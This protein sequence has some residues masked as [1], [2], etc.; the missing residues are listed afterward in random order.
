MLRM[1]LGK[2]GLVLMDT[3]QDSR[4]GPNEKSNFSWKKENLQQNLNHVQ[5]E[6]K[7]YNLMRKLEYRLIILAPLTLWLKKW[8]LRLKKL[9][10]PK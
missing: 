5:L 3:I 2:S 7:N 1:I 4:M 9:G 6:G 10:K 8:L